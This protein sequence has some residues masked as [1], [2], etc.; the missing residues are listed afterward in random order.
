MIRRHE[1]FGTKRNQGICHW[2]IAKVPPN[3]TLPRLRPDKESGEGGGYLD[4]I[5]AY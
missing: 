3:N 4:Y 1:F 5:F 2:F